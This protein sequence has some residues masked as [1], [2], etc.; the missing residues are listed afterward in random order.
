MSI[1]NK[2]FTVRE[3]LSYLWQQKAW[4][5]IPMFLVLLACGLIIFFA[6]PAVITPFLYT[7]I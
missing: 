4:W 7:T 5:L 1:A 2:L 6:Q 3:L